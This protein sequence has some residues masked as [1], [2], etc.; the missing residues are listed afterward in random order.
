[1]YR[2][3]AK[4]IETLEAKSSEISVAKDIVDILWN[5]LKS[6]S[7]QIWQYRVLMDLL[8]DFVGFNGRSS[9]S[10]DDWIQYLWDYA[11]TQK[12]QI[13]DQDAVLVTTIHQAKGKEFK[14][15]FL[16]DPGDVGQGKKPGQSME[17]ERR[18][19]YV[20]LTRAMEFATVFKVNGSK[21]PFSDE[22]L[23]AQGYVIRRNGEINNQWLLI[24]KN[25]PTGMKVRQMGLSDIWA[26][27][28]AREP[29]RWFD[30]DMVQNLLKEIPIGTPLEFCCSDFTPG[31]ED[32]RT[33]EIHYGGLKLGSLSQATARHYQ[34]T[35]GITVEVGA[36]IQCS[37]DEN[38]GYATLDKYYA[39]LP[40][41]IST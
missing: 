31:K 39:I 19:Y 29:S 38:D 21:T 41:V 40:K 7:E 23:Q 9:I 14:Q 13:P 5:L 1:M 35:N 12:G 2:E 37:K 27:S 6:E 16:L 32:V 20:G 25:I 33:V 36:V 4:T 22:L 3:V 17:D 28:F 30:R 11:A 34:E 15:V 26:A 18:L 24:D 8:R 10:V